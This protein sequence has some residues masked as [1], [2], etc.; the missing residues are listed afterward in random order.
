[1]GAIYN[2]CDCKNNDPRLEENLPVLYHKDLINLNMP[3]PISSKKNSLINFNSK[4]TSDMIEDIR[5]KNAINLIIKYYRKH[6]LR[7]S[8]NSSSDKKYNYKALKNKNKLKSKNNMNIKISRNNYNNLNIYFSKNSYKSNSSFNKY[9]YKNLSKDLLNNTI[10][11]IGEKINN[12]KNGFGIK[13]MD[14][15]VKYIGFFKNN[16]SEGLGKFLTRTD[17]YYG[18]FLNDQSN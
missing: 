18:E 12:E 17:S 14:N 7:S 13:I 2:F 6:K 15:E 8:Y 5:R 11:Y 9:K 10:Y 16:K 3:S 1:M 4:S